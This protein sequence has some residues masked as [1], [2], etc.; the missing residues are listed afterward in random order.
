M[1]KPINQ[2]DILPV[3]QILSYQQIS[4]LEVIEELLL[5]KGLEIAGETRSVNKK[6]LDDM[7]LVHY[8]LKVN[9]T[10]KLYV[11]LHLDRSFLK[12]G[13][14]LANGKIK[15]PM[16]IWEKVRGIHA[17]YRTELPVRICKCPKEHRRPLP[18]YDI[19]EC[20][21]CN[22]IHRIKSNS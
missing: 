10:N 19:E 6:L 20:T 1:N 11:G 3:E 2:K 16:E 21:L 18:P 13:L 5:F 14:M 22:D 12:L 9:S 8:N 7:A 17:T 15:V 4:A